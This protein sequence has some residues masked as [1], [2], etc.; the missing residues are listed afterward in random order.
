MSTVLSGFRIFAVSAMKWTPHRT[1]TSAVGLAPP[2]WAR[3]SESPTIVGDA[4][5]DLRGLVVVREDD[6]VPLLL[7]APGWRRRRG[8][9]PATRSPGSRSSASRTSRRWPRP[10]PGCTRA[11][12]SPCRRRLRSSRPRSS[13]YA[14]HEHNGS[15][16]NQPWTTA[17]ILILCVSITGVKRRLEPSG[18]SGGTARRASPTPGARR[19]R[20]TSRRKRNSSAG[21]PPVRD[22]ISEVPSTRPPFSTSRRK[23]CL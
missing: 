5:E 19:S 7:Q 2:R 14:R 22:S 15:L 18:A 6:G 16:K 4:V 12:P 11:R 3:A 9:G 21:R 23:F 20:R 8:R 13:H 10:R 17:V 1:M